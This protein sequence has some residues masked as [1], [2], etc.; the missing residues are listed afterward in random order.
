VRGCY[1]AALGINGGTRWNMKITHL[2]SSLG[3]QTFIGHIRHKI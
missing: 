3:L 1:H 2:N